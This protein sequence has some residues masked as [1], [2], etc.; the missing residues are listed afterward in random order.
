MNELEELKAE[1]AALKKQLA[2]WKPF[3]VALRLEDKQVHLL[4]IL[5]REDLPDASPFS[6]VP[7]E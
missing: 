3:R 5:A 2:G 6:V 7:R 1:V 4:T